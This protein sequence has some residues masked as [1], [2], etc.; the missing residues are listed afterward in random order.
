MNKLMT[1]GTLGLA[2]LV[3]T[4]L[5][6]WQAPLAV[7]DQGSDDSGRDD[8]GHHHG[9]AF[10]RD[11]D[12]QAVVTTVDDDDDDDT[13]LGNGTSTGTNTGTNTGADTGTNTGAD[14]RGGDTDHSRDASV[15]DLTSDGPGSGNVDHS[16]HHTNDGTRHNT[17]G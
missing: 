12:S 13:G 10:K 5:I 8:R 16:R 1:S 9:K 4:G 14:T 7:A 3:T 17:R 2:S 6:A 15:R 11:D